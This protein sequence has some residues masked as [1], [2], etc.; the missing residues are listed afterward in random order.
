[1]AIVP[2]GLSDEKAAKLLAG[3]REGLTIRHLWVTPS[4]LEVY[5][6]ARPEFERV[7]RPLVQAN[8]AAARLRKGIALKNR[9]H[10]R[11]GHPLSGTNLLIHSKGWR[12]CRICDTK[13]HDENRRMS[14]EQARRVVDALQ[15][16]KTVANVTKSG[17]DDYILNHRALLLFRKK[18]PKYDRLVFRLSTANAK[19]HRIEAAARRFQ[20]VR[21]PTIAEHGADIFSL[22]RG[23]VQ[24]ICQHRFETT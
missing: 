12:C 14:E 11:L 22:I 8:A 23:A 9:T 18:H 6:K 13:S 2:N 17:T 1:M 19:V 20:I 21:A 5:F 15:A 4:R 10:C 24:T 3:L 7:A 16:G